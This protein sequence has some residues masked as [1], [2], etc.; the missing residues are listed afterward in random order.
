VFK[1]CQFPMHIADWHPFGVTEMMFW[2]DLSRERGI[3][4]AYKPNPR[5]IKIDELLGGPSSSARRR[6]KRGARLASSTPA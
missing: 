1:E 6:D 4:V 2:R 5:D 3:Q